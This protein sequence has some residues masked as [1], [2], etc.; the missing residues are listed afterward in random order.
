M[1]YELAEKQRIARTDIERPIKRSTKGRA[2]RNKKSEKELR[3]EKERL[4]RARQDER[5]TAI[6]LGI[7]VILL[8]SIIVGSFINHL[9]NEQIPTATVELI[10]VT[11][12]NVES[13]IIVRDETFHSSSVTGDINF[14]IDEGTR[15]RNGQ[16]IAT[17]NMRNILTIPDSLDY[18]ESSYEEIETTETRRYQIENSENITEHIRE[19]A[20]LN[21]NTLNADLETTLRNYI[22]IRNNLLVN[23]EEAIIPVPQMQNSL[24][25]TSR[26]IF[27]SYIDSFSWLNPNSMYT[28]TSLQT[29]NTVIP[30]KIGDTAYSGDTAFRI[31]N[32]NTWYIASH[33]CNESLLGISVG[34]S[35]SIHL[36]DIHENFHQ[37]N[38]IVHHLE[39]RTDENFIIF[40]TR[41]YIS[42][43]L[44]Q[45]S[46][47]FKLSAREV[48]GLKVPKEAL[49]TRSFLVVPEIFTT[50]SDGNR[51]I[52]VMTFDGITTSRLFSYREE[53]G[54]IIIPQELSPINLGYT[55]VNSNGQSYTVS[56]IITEEGVFRANIGIATFIPLDLEELFFYG[57][58]AIISMNNQGRSGLNPHDRIVADAQNVLVYE[59]MA[60]F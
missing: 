51:Y 20:L 39:K 56:N 3:R 18:E 49:S 2:K 50:L 15:V 10:N 1:K 53:N 57:N 11:Y 52:N 44:N 19:V 54:Y 46:V 42:N 55:V 34:Q 30:E 29:N 14:H 28:L 24:N 17:V 25:A 45:R 4:R 37:V 16:N 59:G 33:I 13:G 58:Y 43:F 27:T 6:T 12:A 40:R 48:S 7:I 32:S 26:G 60:V 47:N 5:A 38:M 22:E 23:A 41:D 31:V 36:Q 21:V 8:I 35:I 9:T